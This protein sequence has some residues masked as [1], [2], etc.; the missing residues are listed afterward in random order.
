MNKILCEQ[1][2]IDYCCTPEDILDDKNHFTKHE[3]LPGRRK[4]REDEECFLK[5]AAIN[6]KV[7]F[8]GNAEIIKWCS[9]NFKGD[10]SEW[11]FE[12]ENLSLLVNRLG[13]SEYMIKSIHPFF[14]SETISDVDTK[15]FEIDWYRDEE[16]ER[17]RG[18][19]RFDEAYSFCEDAPDVLG[20]SASKDGKILG[21]AGASRDS[22]TMWQIGINVDPDCREAGIGKMLVALLKNEILKKGL[23]PFYGTS[24]S[25]LASQRV[26]IGAGFLPAW[27][28]MATEKI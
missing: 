25:H 28:E 14:I 13:E 19:E 4:F 24:V 2:A 6:G 17:F 1:L 18:D 15:D 8:C 7:L 26:A 20:V 12:G 16:I 11:F 10:G 27:F 22:E 21:M 9:E 5:I 23:L 3:F